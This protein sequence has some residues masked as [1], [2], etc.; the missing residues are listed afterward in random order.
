MYHTLPLYG[1]LSQLYSCL[2]YT[3]QE[4]RHM[5]IQKT[6]TTAAVGGITPVSYTHLDV[7]KRQHLQRLQ[8]H[9]E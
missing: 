3:S 7:Y 4:T 1:F 8:M 2:L 6:I 5:E 9:Y